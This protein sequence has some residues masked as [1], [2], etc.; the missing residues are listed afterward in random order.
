MPTLDEVVDNLTATGG[1][2]EIETVD[3]RGVPTKVFS[4]RLE[5]LRELSRLAY[6]KRGE[7]DLLVYGDSRYSYREFFEFANSA[8]K[9]LERDHDLARG[10]R[11]AILSANNPTWCFVFWATLNSS[12]IAVGLN[13]WW[14]ADEI[15][16]GVQDSG[17]RILVVDRDRFVRIRDHLSEIAGVEAIFLIDPEP[18]DLDLDSR[19]H[20]AADLLREPS[21]DFSDVPIDEDDPAVILYTSGTTGR[22]KGAVATHRS[23]LAST[24]N[25]SGVAAVTAAVS[26]SDKPPSTGSDVRL[27]CVPLF[28]V[29]GAQSHLVAGLLAGWKLVMPEGG[30]VADKMLHLIEDEGVT[31]WAAVPTM[32][33]RVC[34]HPDRHLFDLTHVTNIGYGG[35]PAPAELAAAVRETFPNVSYQANIYGLTETSGVATING[36]QARLDRPGSVGRGLLTVDVAIC[37]ERGDRLPAGTTGE[38]N[39]RGPLLISGYWDQPEAT[40]EAIVDGWLRTGDIGFLD[41]DDYLFITDRAK[42][43]IIRGGENVYSVEIE[44]RLAAHAAV[45]EAAVI[46]IPHPDLGEA[47]KAF[48][49]TEPEASLTV[50]ELQTWVAETL[51][52]FKVPSV[53]EISPEPLPRTATGKVLKNDLRDRT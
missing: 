24:H 32:V 42:D 21:P 40:A 8:S 16:Y 6:S 5:S 4:R 28:H 20:D 26:P 11:V 52:N 17:A 2:F 7:R 31:A 43:V 9:V 25:V 1:R 39:V 53:I 13:G 33:S 10:D 35:A 46:G 14:K 36:G 22:P 41:D 47:V 19:I 27:L 49:Q 50:P 45:L 48:V 23:W 51:A 34:Q 15:L 29:S 18:G 12:A 30:F 3:V 44:D 37:D 38:V